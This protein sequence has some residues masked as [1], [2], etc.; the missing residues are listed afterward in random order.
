MNKT[1]KDIISKLEGNVISIGTSESLVSVFKNND[2][3]TECYLL[4]EISR[5]KTKDLSG[6]SIRKI[7]IKKLKKKF[8]NIDYIVCSYE[9]IRKYLRKR[10]IF[11]EK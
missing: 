5:G 11:M 3:I 4:D 7:N 9:Q 1:I 10:S 2:K 8:K 6:S